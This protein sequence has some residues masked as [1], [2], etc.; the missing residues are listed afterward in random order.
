MHSLRSHTPPSDQCFLAQQSRTK[1]Q[2]E[3]SLCLPAQILRSNF[4]NRE[5]HT[6]KIGGHNH[7]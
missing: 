2:I 6:I 7:E 5:N 1:K 4:K 3:I